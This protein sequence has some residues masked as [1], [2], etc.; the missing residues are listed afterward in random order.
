MKKSLPLSISLSL[1][2][3]I[4]PS[5]PRVFR[6]VV[7][8]LR[9]FGGVFNSCSPRKIKDSRS[10]GYTADD[11]PRNS[12]QDFAQVGPFLHCSPPS[13]EFKTTACSGIDAS[14]GNFNHQMPPLPRGQIAVRRDGFHCGGN[15]HAHKQVKCSMTACVA[16]PRIANRVSRI[17][18]RQ[19]RV[20]HQRDGLLF[21]VY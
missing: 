12:F 11:H 1:H 5:H 15:F 4:A 21:T 18:Y 9:V 6:R 10:S 8:V 19:L 17:A 3:S 2:H 13:H 14:F 16:Q 20:A 7:F